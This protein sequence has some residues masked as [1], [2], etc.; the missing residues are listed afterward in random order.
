ME[1]TSLTV[2][3]R[4]EGTKTDFAFIVVDV[5]VVV[6]VAIVVVVVV[7]VVVVTIAVAAAGDEEA[8]NVDVNN[9]ADIVVRAVH[10]D[11]AVTLVEALT[12][13]G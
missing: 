10:V 2:L 8:G 6:V 13:V 11:G 3:D 1:D 12:V 4:K 7:V 9:E 5:V